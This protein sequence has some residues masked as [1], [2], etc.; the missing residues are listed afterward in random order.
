MQN[1]I[2]NHKECHL[3]SHCKKF[4]IC[5][6]ILIQDMISGKWKILILWYLSYHT[7]RFSDLQKRLPNVSQKVLSRQL[8]SLEEDHLIAKKIYPVVPPKVEYSLTPLGQKVIPILE[9]MHKFGSDYL[10]DN[11]H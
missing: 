1:Y 4:E 9:A 6:M 7:L 5:P 3:N 8:K 11:H 2:G 10:E